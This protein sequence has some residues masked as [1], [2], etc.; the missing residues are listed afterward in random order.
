[1]SNLTT[2]NTFESAIVDT[3]CDAGRYRQ[4]EGNDYSAEIGMFKEEVIAFLRQTQ[5]KRWEKIS[6]IHGADV[7][8][9]V[10]ARLYKELDLRGSLDVLRNGLPTMA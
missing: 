10:L 8:K 3:L 1:M 2:E 6:A 9:R 5:P 4:I 7:E